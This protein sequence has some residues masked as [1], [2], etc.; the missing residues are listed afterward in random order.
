MIGTHCCQGRLALWIS[1]LTSSK[2]CIAKQTDCCRSSYKW[3]AALSDTDW[4]TSGLQMWLRGDWPLFPWWSERNSAF[5]FFNLS[6]TQTMSGMKLKSDRHVCAA[7]ACFF[8]R[9]AVYARPIICSSRQIKRR[10]SRMRCGERCFT[11]LIITTRAD[12][13][14]RSVLLISRVYARISLCREI[15][16]MCNRWLTVIMDGIHSK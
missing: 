6:F 7:T 14:T 5:E 3:T 2:E 12:D 11:L 13:G 8:M 16:K 1:P 9:A 15:I 10:L 4:C